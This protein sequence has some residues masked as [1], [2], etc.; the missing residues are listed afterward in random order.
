AYDSH[1]KDDETSLFDQE[2]FAYAHEEIGAYD[3]LSALA[4]SEDEMDMDEPVEVD[5]TPK[6]HLLYKLPTIDLFAPDKPK[7]QSKEKNLV[8]KNIKVLEDT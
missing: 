5:F 4:S 2:D 1:L 8:R 7:N 6:T 3:S